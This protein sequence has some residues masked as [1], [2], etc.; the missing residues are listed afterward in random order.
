MDNKSQ[1]SC[2]R[3][4]LQRIVDSA[5][6]EFLCGLLTLVRDALFVLQGLLQGFNMCVDIK[7]H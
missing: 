1:G 6:F 2:G 5:K 4:F 3:A 7:T